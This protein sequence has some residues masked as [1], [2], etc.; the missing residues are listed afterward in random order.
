MV[1]TFAFSHQNLG[2]GCSL[3]KPINNDDIIITVKEEN[4]IFNLIF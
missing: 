2:N 1:I 3:V 4:L